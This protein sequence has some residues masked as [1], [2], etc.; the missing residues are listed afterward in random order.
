MGAQRLFGER[1]AQ[2][3]YFNCRRRRDGRAH[4]ERTLNFSRRNVQG[5]G[6]VAFNDM[7]A[8]GGYAFYGT[9]R[10]HLACRLQ[11]TSQRS[12]KEV[13]CLNEPKP[14]SSQPGYGGIEG[15]SGPFFRCDKTSGVV[16]KSTLF[17][18]DSSHLECSSASSSK[19]QSQGCQTRQPGNALHSTG[20]TQ[21]EPTFGSPRLLMSLEGPE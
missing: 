14:R 20:T 9:K 3:G 8:H 2:I 5:G 13:G 6:D 12:P 15:W 1:S 10:A 18:D 16:S 19:A 11:R 21:F 4:G 7:Y 17:R